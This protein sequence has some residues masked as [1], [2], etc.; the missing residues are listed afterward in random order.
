MSCVKNILLGTSF[1]PLLVNPLI[2][3]SL[4][5][6]KHTFNLQSEKQIVAGRKHWK[7]IN[8]CSAI[9]SL[10]ITNA[11]IEITISVRDDEII[12]TKNISDKI[13]LYFDLRPLRLKR[14]NFYEPGVFQLIINNDG[15]K[16]QYAPA[17]YTAPVNNANISAKTTDNGYKIKVF[18]PWT[19]LKDTH[20][21]VFY[22]FGFDFSVIDA[23]SNQKET[24]KMVYW[25][26]DDNWRYPNKFKTV[27]IKEPDTKHPNLILMFTD[28][29]TIQAIS[30]SGNSNLYTPNMDALA[31]HGISFQRSYCTAP[32]SGPARS[33]LV[34]GLM[35]HTTAVK[36][37]GDAL[38]ENI[39]TMGQVF[40]KAG[41]E[42]RWAGKWHL[43]ESYPHTTKDSV[44]GFR[45]IHFLEKEKMTGKGDDTDHHL[46][47][48][49]THYLQQKH[50]KPFLLG[51]SFH[52]PHDI[53]YVPRQPEKY[54]FPVNIRSAP[55]LP[56]NHA[57]APDEPLFLKECRKRNYY[58]NELFLARNFS[59]QAW[60]N[61]LF[62][63]YRMTERVDKQVG[64][65]INALERNGLDRNTL[66]IF[67]SDHGDGVAAH[68]WA[69]KLS[70]YREA[71]KVPFVVTW[72]G[73]TPENI[74][75]STNLV[76]GID[77][78]PT[79]CDYAGVP[80]PD[81]VVGKS[82]KPVV[83]GKEKAIR[84]YIVTELAPFPKEPEKTARMIV[85]GK[86]K[87]NIYYYG[88]SNKQLFDM[89]LD[90][91]ENR[92]L[93]HLKK[94]QKEAEKLETMLKEWCRVTKDPFIKYLG[95]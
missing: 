39:T 15:K 32:V 68:Q 74:V 17:T 47:K 22:D 21:Q 71:V 69:A 25:G 81:W 31:A 48:A 70:L 11:G 92:N 65:V 88:D 44:Q 52:N 29:Q 10:Q 30:A 62:H 77:V 57:P 28:Q 43:P 42:T 13:E 54:P 1:V 94:Y 64:R 46:A 53:C 4:A 36:Y 72:L 58:G 3:S 38:H 60:R 33:S 78:F 49:V 19:G 27:T 67:T 93:I 7:S 45:L 40:H 24:T 14:R 50:K 82:L 90:P 80:I 41:Y 16:I 56:E 35:P 6:N 12:S 85:S 9:S 61:Y 51:V 91:E 76:S 26:D 55:D 79:F 18:L 86:Y 2:K 87:L 66:I 73:K 5:Q 63:Y 75:D 84:Q 8:D 37:N 20:Y 95:K 59:N 23:D 34:T 83:D 89:E